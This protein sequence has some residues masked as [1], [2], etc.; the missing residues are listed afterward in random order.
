MH[1]LTH[2]EKVLIYCMRYMGLPPLTSKTIYSLSLTLSAFPLNPELSFPSNDDQIKE[3]NQSLSFFA[4]L[5]F[6]NG[7]LHD[8]EE[9]CSHNVPADGEEGTHHSLRHWEG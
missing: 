8:E 6:D 5:T 9:E 7:S 3:E 1:T 4:L 2:H